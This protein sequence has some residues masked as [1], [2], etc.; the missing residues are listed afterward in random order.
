M[1]PTLYDITAKMSGEKA[2]SKLD[3]FILLLA[4]STRTGMRQADYVYNA[5]WKFLLQT[6]AC[7]IC[8][9]KMKEL[10]GDMSGAD[11]S[12]DDIIVCGC[13]VAEHDKRLSRGLERIP[14]SSMKL[15]K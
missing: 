5:I 2:F 3:F 13:T 6:P 4:I 1:L 7:E 9:R 12:T 10:C 15:N 14:S 8:Q 11:V